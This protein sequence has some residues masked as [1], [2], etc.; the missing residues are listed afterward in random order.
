MMLINTLLAVAALSLSQSGRDP[1]QPPIVH[2]PAA[3]T[4]AG[5]ANMTRLRASVEGDR[6]RGLQV[7]IG[8]SQGT[9]P[10]EG[11]GPQYFVRAR[12]Q[13][14]DSRASR[15]LGLP[16]Y[17]P[18]QEITIPIRR[19]EGLISF[20]LWFPD[21]ASFI[22]CGHAGMPD[23]YELRVKL[24]IDGNHRLVDSTLVEVAH[25]GPI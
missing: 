2:L 13:A 23:S 4:C 25:L 10:G 20:S 9:G 1:F 17:R 5:G 11:L 19:V 16:E 24:T 21:R 7:V 6:K 8:W 22:G 12:L 18:L 15:A 14:D 3:D